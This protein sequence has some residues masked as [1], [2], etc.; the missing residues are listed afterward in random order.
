MTSNLGAS[1]NERN[2]IGFNDLA[3]DSEDDKAIKK[4]FAPEFRNRLDAIIKFSKL[5]EK[6]V[7]QIVKK[8]VGDLNSQLKDKGIE[9]V[10]TAK[11]TKWLATRG[12]DLTAQNEYSDEHRQHY[13]HVIDYATWQKFWSDWSHWD[14]VSPESPHGFYRRLDIEEYCWS[15]LNLALSAQTQVV[16]DCIDGYAADEVRDERDEF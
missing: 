6:V 16:E 11:A 14:D 15:Q 1:D 13:N 5:G 12:H 9:I 7:E 3:R 4:F 2:T 10:V 8:F